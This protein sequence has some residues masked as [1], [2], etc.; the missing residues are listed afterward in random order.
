[1]D[2]S[3]FVPVILTIH[4]LIVLALIGVVLL[5]RSE[6]GALGIGGGGGGGFMSGR[7]AANVL[8]RSTSIL[9]ALFFAT[10]LGLAIVADQGET[11][12][13][14]IEDF[15]GVDPNEVSDDP[16]DSDSLIRSIGGSLG[17][18][19]PS[20]T[21]EE[22]PA[23]PVD[24]PVDEPAP[25]ADDTPAPDSQGEPPAGQASEDESEPPSR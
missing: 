2:L 24:E 17:T 9:A 10:S 14:I 23:A 12:A 7:G 1:M 8:T 15:T 25:V 6:G 20:D 21:P 5:Q 13:E 16:F 11:E 4:V 18:E 22:A 19:T 3:S